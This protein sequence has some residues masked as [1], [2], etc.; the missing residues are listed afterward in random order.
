MNLRDRLER[1]RG[2]GLAP[3]GIPAASTPSSRRSPAPVQPALEAL[4]LSTRPTPWGE[5][6]F[7]E[8][9][10]PAGEPRGQVAPARL[11]SLPL[12]PLLRFGRV[13]APVDSA[14]DLL[15]LDTET[16]GLAGGTGTLVVVAGLAR[17]D[18]ARLRI[19]QF[20]LV[21][22]TAEAAFLDAL[23][24]ELER[25][26]LLV[27]FNGRRFDWP[28]LEARFVLNRG[29]RA[30]PSPPHLDLLY[31]AR[32]LYGA[33]LPSCRLADLEAQV[34]GARRA[35]DSPGSEVPLRYRLL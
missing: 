2:L 31:P 8:D 30:V 14:E 25:A 21:D 17:L 33:D 16:T 32:R 15:F 22:P 11:A 4:A 12:E 29:L 26:R 27:T 34:L 19:R 28:V 35:G 24:G 23:A 18:G 10:M 3:A 1:L 5:A 13:E 20:V 6:C 7:R 9:D